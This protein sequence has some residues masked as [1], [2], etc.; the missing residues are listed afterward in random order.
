MSEWMSIESAPRD[1]T[2]ILAEIPGHGS[3]CVI[4]WSGGL[5]DSN[6]DECGGWEYLEGEP[7]ECWTDGVCWEVNA[8][9]QK[10]MHPTRWKPLAHPLPLPRQEG[11]GW[12]ARTQSSVIARCTGPAMT[13]RSPVV[14]A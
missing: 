10:S 5:L 4:A 13:R 9:G 7:P 6:G 8:E 14:A 3:D 2:A 1:G 12:V 11:E